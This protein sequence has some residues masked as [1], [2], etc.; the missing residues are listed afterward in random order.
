MRTQ[1]DMYACMYG[2]RINDYARGGY[3]VLNIEG[4]EI[5]LQNLEWGNERFVIEFRH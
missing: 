1:T 4:R 5:N 3:F 2:Q